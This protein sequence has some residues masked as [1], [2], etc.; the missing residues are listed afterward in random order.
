[1]NFK[2]VNNDTD[3]YTAEI[4]KKLVASYAENARLKARLDLMPESE[5]I[6]HALIKNTP[7]MVF[8]CLLDTKS[9]HLHFTYASEGS[10]LLLGLAPDEILSNC[11]VIGDR[12]ADNDRELFYASL[13]ASANSMEVWNWEGKTIFIEGMEKWINCRAT[14]RFSHEGDVIWEG[15]ILNITESKKSEH[16]LQQSEK[17]LRELSAHGEIVREEERKRVAREV[18][19]ELGQ[20]LTVLRMDV[21]LLCLNFSEK[22][23]QMLSQLQSMKDKV[24]KTI[25]IMRHITSTLRPISLDLGLVAGLEWL[26]EEFVSHAGINCQ[27]QVNGPEDVMLDDGRATALFRI[28]QESLT[29]VV[30]H[31]EASEVNVFIDFEKNEFICLE[32]RDDGKGF[33]PKTR[34]TGSFGLIGINER[35]MMLGGTCRINSALGNGTCVVVCIPFTQ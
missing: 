22:H 10:R 31:A 4:Q 3:A 35:A 27:L 1:M 12:L 7:G 28:V 9:G 13:Y 5:Q 18:H 19:D 25:K 26:V 20:A 15:V 29:N 32:I 11:N 6:I 8:Q 16:A 33:I 23:P 30:K 34:K 21:S 24:D 14:P 17:L 2:L